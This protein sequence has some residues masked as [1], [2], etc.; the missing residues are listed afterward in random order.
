[1]YF[2][3]KNEKVGRQG[4]HSATVRPLAM[5]YKDKLTR[6]KSHSLDYIQDLPPN[7]NIFYALGLKDN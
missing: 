4:S 3:P 7:H 1:M 6:K 2:G 5:Q